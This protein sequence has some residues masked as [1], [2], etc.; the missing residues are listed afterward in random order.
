M[1]S[2]EYMARQGYPLVTTQ[3][4]QHI[5]YLRMVSDASDGKPGEFGTG[6][7]TT[8]LDALRTLYW[9]GR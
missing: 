5:D 3:H 7:I 8:Q 1:I 6:V 4:L 9:R 2:Y